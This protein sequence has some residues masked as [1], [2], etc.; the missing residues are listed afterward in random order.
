M[1]KSS[2][3]YLNSR[4][5]LLSKKIIHNRIYR[6]FLIRNKMISGRMNLKTIVLILSEEWVTVLRSRGINCFKSLLRDNLWFW[7][8]LRFYYNMPN[9]NSTLKTEQN[10]FHCTLNWMNPLFT[11]FALR[12][13]Y[14]YTSTLESKP[15][16]R[17][18]RKK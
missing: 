18:C 4:R 16:K 15:I 1:N 8:T 11:K 17:K 3:S 5:F 6:R 7:L 13:S 14:G 9:W 2:L 12:C 10:T